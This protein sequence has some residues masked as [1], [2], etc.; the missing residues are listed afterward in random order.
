[1]RTNLKG[2]AKVTSKG[3]D[4]YYAWRGGPRLKGEPG[5]PEFVQSYNEA[6]ADFK[7]P[8]ASRFRSL[9]VDYKA[10]QDYAD[11]ADKTRE[12]RGPWLDRIADYF[13][14]LRIAQFERPEKI[15]PLI[16]EWHKKWAA[17]PRTADYGLQVLSVV[18]GY[19]V[20]NGKLASNPSE[21]IKRLYVAA[22]RSEIIWSDDDLKKLKA[23]GGPELGHAVDLA[24]YTGLRKGDLLR[25]P[26]TAVGEDAIVTTTSKSIRRKGGVIVKRKEAIIPLYDELREVLAHIPKRSPIILTNDGQPWTTDS[27]GGAFKRA[28]AKAGLANLR[29]HDLRGTAATKFYI[30]GLPI[31]VIAEIVGWEEDHVEAII[32]RYVGRHAATKALIAKLNEQRRT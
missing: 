16:R 11:K 30:A 14:D 21:G 24:A 32:R 19:A 12:G 15:R 23:T 18:L 4:Y 13:G 6:V 17:T 8:D 1:M 10:S 29:F 3:C 27:F 9:V 31:R 25:L 20:E 7:A 5:T 28:K 2:I 22:D 26:W